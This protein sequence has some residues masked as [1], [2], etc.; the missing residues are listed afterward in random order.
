MKIYNINDKMKSALRQKGR[1][2]VIKNREYK[3]KL[4]KI[5]KFDKITQK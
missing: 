2:F 1:F 5:K 4:R 3:N